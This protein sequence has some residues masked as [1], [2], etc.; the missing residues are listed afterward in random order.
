MRSA[1]GIQDIMT[2]VDVGTVLKEEKEHKGREN[3][4]GGGSERMGERN[5]EKENGVTRE[6]EKLRSLYFYN[7]YKL[8][9][10]HF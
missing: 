5:S 3:G 8:K 7:L 1:K 2:K 10:Q 9:C 6:R 4:G